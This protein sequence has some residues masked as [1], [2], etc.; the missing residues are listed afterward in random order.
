M[1]VILITETQ[2]AFNFLVKR[3]RSIA[4]A[5]QFYLF[6]YF[7]FYLFALPLTKYNYSIQNSSQWLNISGAKPSSGK[8]KKKRTITNQDTLNTVNLGK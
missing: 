2:T 5:K 1:S 6:I 8:K 4:F 7:I 3:L